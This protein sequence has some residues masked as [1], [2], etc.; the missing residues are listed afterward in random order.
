M[1][2][3]TTT[4]LTTILALVGNKR[5]PHLEEEIFAD[6]ALTE[7][8]L[9]KL[10]TGL[11][12]RF[13]SEYYDNNCHHPDTLILEYARTVL[14]ARWLEAEHLIRDLDNGFWWEEYSVIFKINNTTTNS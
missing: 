8:Y 11:Q 3:T 5:L 10:Y 14:N 13:S 1:M 9:R 2:M 6:T 4:E 7:I 12:I